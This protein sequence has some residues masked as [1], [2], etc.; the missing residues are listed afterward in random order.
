MTS[1]GYLVWSKPVDVHRT[2]EVWRVKLHKTK[3]INCY[4]TKKVNTDYLYF[5]KNW[6]RFNSNLWWIWYFED[7]YA[8][9]FPARETIL[10]AYPIQ[11]LLGD[12]APT[13]YLDPSQWIEENLIY[14]L[15]K[16]EA[17][18]YL[19]DILL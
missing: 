10:H 16:P 17:Y 18:H 3:A 19:D 13:T 7:C 9:I 12:T 8:D 1:K 4:S 2:H 11:E 14:S 15:N 6:D 5:V